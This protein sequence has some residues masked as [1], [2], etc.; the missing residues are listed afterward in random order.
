MWRCTSKIV[1]K[2]KVVEIGIVILSRYSSSRFHGKALHIINKKTLIDHIVDNFKNILPEVKCVIAT[3][4]E[5]T[6]DIIWEHCKSKRIECFR[7]S[8]LNVSERVLKCSLN[9]KWNYFVRIN[10]D[11]LFN[12][13]NILSNVMNEIDITDFDFISNVQGRTFPYGISIEIIKTSFYQKIIRNFYSDH[14][15]EHV[16]SWLYENEEHGKRYTIKNK[17]FKN[18]AGVKLSIDTIKDVEIAKKIIEFNGGENYVPLKV[19]DQ[20]LI[21]K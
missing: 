7:G 13:P 8:L 3:S 2:K 14:H 12:D 20:F 19:L 5:K 1:K 17:R 18:L 16:T 15:K 9:Y 6:D 10:G 11:N 4:T 21:N